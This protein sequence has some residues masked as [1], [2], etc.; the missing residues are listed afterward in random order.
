MRISCL[1]P[2]IIDYWLLD[3]ILEC[4]RQKSKFER[5]ITLISVWNRNR[6]KLKTSACLLIKPSPTGLA[7]GKT[8][9]G[10]YE[11]YTW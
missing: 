3:V 10:T 7:A 11:G 2:L 5:N 8:Q 4:C 1:N 6:H 9:N